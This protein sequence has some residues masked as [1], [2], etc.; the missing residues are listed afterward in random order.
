VDG[1]YRITAS[2]QGDQTVAVSTPFALTVTP[3]ALV[4]L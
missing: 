4:P 1:G 3:T 2:G